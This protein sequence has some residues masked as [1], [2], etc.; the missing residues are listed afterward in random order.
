M[1]QK[2][3]EFKRH[4]LEMQGNELYFFTKENDRDHKFMHCLSGTYLKEVTDDLTDS[5]DEK[6]NIQYYSLKMV[7]PPNKSRILYF[8]S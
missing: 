6:N 4:W 3:E 1:K 2:N 7:I 5:R 8:N